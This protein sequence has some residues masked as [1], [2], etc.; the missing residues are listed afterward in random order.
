MLH[1]ATQARHKYE[2]YLAKQKEAKTSESEK[3]KRKCLEE[4]IE[5]LRYQAK[6]AKLDMESLNKSAVEYAVKAEKERNFSHIAKSN[7]LRDKA[8]EKGN[9]CD[10]LDT[11]LKEKLGE[12]K[13][14]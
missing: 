5:E 3:R 11:K 9:L 14:V 7:A 8:N 2:E 6:Q 1:S 10:Q 12:L 13:T 4:S